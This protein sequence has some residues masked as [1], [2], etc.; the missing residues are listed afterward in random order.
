M[1][2]LDFIE[3]LGMGEPTTEPDTELEVKDS[4]DNPNEDFVQDSTEEVETTEET[5]TEET[6]VPPELVELKKQVEGMEKRIADKDA[7][8]EQLRE[9][10]K[11]REV[12]KEE[13]QS[14]DGVEDDFWDDPVGYVNKMK[15]EF[16]NQSRVQQMQINEA[17]Y[18]NTV[19]DYWKTVNQDA[20]KE[21]VA[22][23]AK[24]YESFNNS[25]EPYKTAYEYLSQ[26]K[27]AVKKSEDDLRARIR[28]EVMDEL[29][30][31][32]KKETVPSTTNL[33]GKSSNGK[34]NEPED[35]FLSVFGR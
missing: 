30:L 2:N 25:K 23:D 34:S 13:T 9:E 22:T 10:S 24:F 18:A 1:S 28:Q 27:N 12:A 33:G 14:E 29:K 3:Q 4:Q 11:A 17:V 26:K 6:T 20:L 7:Y 5:I 35:G 16:T 8:I 19:D 15:E 32:K 21:A 31:G